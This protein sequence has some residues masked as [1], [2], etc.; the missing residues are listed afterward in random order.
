M[1]T[2]YQLATLK[3]GNSSITDYYQKAKQYVD[4]LAFIGQ[5]LTE[6]EITTYLHPHRFAHLI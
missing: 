5:P 1:K 6:A 2:W 4:L 3:K